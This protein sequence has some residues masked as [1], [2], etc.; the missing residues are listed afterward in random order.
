MRDSMTARW[1]TINND[2]RFGCAKMFTP[3]TL[4]ARS[5]TVKPQFLSSDAASNIDFPALAWVIIPINHLY[6]TFFAV[7]PIYF[8]P[9]QALMFWVYMITCSAIIH[10]ELIQRLLLA[11]THLVFK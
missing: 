11:L 6:W 10:V 7:F 1:R 9:S 3:A 4:F 8:S 2:Q 5:S